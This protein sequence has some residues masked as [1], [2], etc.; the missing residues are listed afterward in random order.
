MGSIYLGI[1]KKSMHP[2]RFDT[3]RTVRAVGVSARKDG[4]V[5]VTLEILVVWRILK[6]IWT[7]L[8]GFE[9]SDDV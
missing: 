2:D 8:F 9:G 5:N 1:M 4:T 7:R 6:R 3:G